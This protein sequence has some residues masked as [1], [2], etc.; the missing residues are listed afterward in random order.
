M[1][2]A[3]PA[4]VWPAHPDLHQPT[5][6]LGISDPTLSIPRTFP[7]QRGKRWPLIRISGPSGHPPE[8]FVLPEAHSQVL[9]IARRWTSEVFQKL[10][11]ST[12]T[13]VRACW[14]RLCPDPPRSGNP[15]TS[16]SPDPAWLLPHLPL[17]T[18]SCITHLM[19]GACERLSH[20]RSFSSVASAVVIL[21][22]RPA[23]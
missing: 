5:T 15:S 13:H 2:T 3:V 21:A 19:A 17:P 12:F 11:R 7:N 23:T 9:I 14:F 18:S 6:V 20:R 10:R 1:W 8:R 4:Q 22:T 16:E